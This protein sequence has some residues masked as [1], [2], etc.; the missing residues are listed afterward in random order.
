MDNDWV[1]MLLAFGAVIAAVLAA[2]VLTL[3]VFGIHP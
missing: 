1:M 2:T 3:R